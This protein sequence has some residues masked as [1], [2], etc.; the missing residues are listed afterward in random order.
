M[1]KHHHTSWQGLL[2][3][4]C[5][6]V[7]QNLHCHSVRTVNDRQP[8]TCLQPPQAT[9][10]LQHTHVDKLVING[11][12]TRQARIS[13]LTALTVYKS[14]EN[15]TLKVWGPVQISLGWRK[16]KERKA[17]SSLWYEG[18]FWRLFQN[19]RIT[20]PIDSLYCTNKCLKA[21]AYHSD[22]QGCFSFISPHIPL[23]LCHTLPV[24]WE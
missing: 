14:N 13:C 7:S 3:S 17:A 6:I 12:W 18:G 22:S 5:S 19:W 9:D 23:S 2:F 20:R 15:R 10:T 21:L 24:C 11:L 1:I 8:M 16:K 4:H